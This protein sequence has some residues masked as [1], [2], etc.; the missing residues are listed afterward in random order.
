MVDRV[1]VGFW[2]H[3]L[4]RRRMVERIFPIQIIEKP[5]WSSNFLCK[6]KTTDFCQPMSDVLLLIQIQPFTKALENISWLSR[7]LNHLEQI[8]HG[9][10]SRVEFVKICAGFRGHCGYL[11][12]LCSSNLLKW[13]MEKFQEEMILIAKLH[14]SR[15]CN[16]FKKY[17]IRLIRYCESDTNESSKKQ[18]QTDLPVFKVSDARAWAKKFI[19]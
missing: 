11:Q 19:K 10:Q 9:S 15:C 2:Q 5:Q 1:P 13:L 12:Y 6:V 7:G 4:H 16:L 17:W 14:R 8:I 18:E 3:H